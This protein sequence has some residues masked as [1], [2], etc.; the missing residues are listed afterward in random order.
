MEKEKFQPNHNHLLI[1]GYCRKPIKNEENLSIFL[2][3]LVEKV[4]MQ[5]I[6]GPISVYVDEPGNEGV[7]GIVSLATS[8]AAIHIWDEQ[9]PAFFQFD[10]YS[11]TLFSENEVIE[12]LNE[13]LDLIEY[14]TLMIDRNNFDFYD[15]Y[16]KNT[17]KNNK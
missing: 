6:G 5:V 3:N 12:Y 14:K 11:C 7:T 2:K 4:R 13:I 8:H 10:L 17:L 9:T 1:Q 15:F 16:T